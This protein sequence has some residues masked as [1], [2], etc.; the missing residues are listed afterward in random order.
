MDPRHDSN[1]GIR[2]VY[3][4]TVTA[5]FSIESRVEQFPREGGQFRIDNAYVMDLGSTR[6]AYNCTLKCLNT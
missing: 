5:P 2:D 1:L 6:N 4:I 3:N